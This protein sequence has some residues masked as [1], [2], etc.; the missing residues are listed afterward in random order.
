MTLRELYDIFLTGRGIS[1]DSRTAKRGQIYVALTGP[2][3]DG[4]DYAREAL[5]KGVKVAIVNRSPYNRKS[6]RVLVVKSP[7]AILQKLAQ[8]HRRNIPA[9]V[10]ALTGSNGKTTTRA[11]IMAL[12]ERKYKV[13]GTKGNLNNHIGLPLTILSAKESDEILIL[14]MG[15]NHVGEI[16]KLAEIAEPDYGLITNIG[17]AHLEG[18]GGLEG[19]KQGKSEL[20]QALGKSDSIAFVNGKGEH[21]LQ[22]STVVFNKVFYNQRLDVEYSALRTHL[23]EVRLTDRGLAFIM[24]TRTAE[25]PVETS[26]Q[27][28]YNINNVCAAVT[29]AE[30]FNVEMEDIVSVLENFEMPANRSQELTREGIRFTADAY[31]A[32]PTSVSAAL[33]SFGRKP[34]KKKHV[35]LGA[36]KELGDASAAEHLEMAKLAKK[37]RGAKIYLVGTEFAEAAEQVGL[38]HYA[39]TEDLI[40]DVKSLLAAG[41]Q[42]LLKGSRAMHLEDVIDQ[43]EEPVIED[44]ES[45]A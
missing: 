4:N 31:N 7:L 28:L 43:Y 30:Y 15:A 36:M 41:D 24:K 16:A 9:K 13:N 29:V 21:L 39:T 2:H 33:D 14:E 12:L 35:I 45:A 17:K 19:V 40:R 10:M 25:Y 3:H 18:F 42:V 38:A 44:E 20:Y 8:Y 34:G 22:M 5:E 11:L 27:G 6:K 26:L 23:D 32:N 37:I 1:T